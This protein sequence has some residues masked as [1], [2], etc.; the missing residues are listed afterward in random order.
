VRIW[1]S[2]HKRVNEDHTGRNHR[3]GSNS[4]QVY[5]T[6]KPPSLFSVSFKPQDII[7]S[8]L[9]GSK[10]HML[11]SK[12]H[13]G[14]IDS[15]NHSRKLDCDSHSNWN[16]DFVRRAF[17]PFGKIYKD[18]MDN[19]KLAGK[20]SRTLFVYSQKMTQNFPSTKER[21]PILITIGHY[22]SCHL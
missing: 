8:T 10:P 2:E 20:S 15:S 18:S 17:R 12:F 22:S 5:T 13:I 14:R 9:S 19:L 1:T 4:L 16:E 6:C 7:I 11:R 21:S 3:S